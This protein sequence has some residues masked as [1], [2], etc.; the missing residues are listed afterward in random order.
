MATQYMNQA[1]ASVTIHGQEMNFESNTVIAELF[2][3]TSVTLLKTQSSNIVVSEGTITYTIIITNN[4][5]DSVSNFNLLDTIPNGMTY[6][7]ESFK[8][9]G[10]A[11]TPTIVDQELSYQFTTLPTGV[12][13]VTFDCDVE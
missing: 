8:I 7:D 10:I 2:E 11:D 3:D 13:T 12:T 6:V 1:T 5:I 4:A 9:N